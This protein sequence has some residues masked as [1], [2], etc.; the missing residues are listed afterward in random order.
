MWN[1]LSSPARVPKAAWPPPHYVAAWQ[2]ESG[3]TWGQQAELAAIPGSRN[4]V[5][6][7]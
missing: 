2:Q 6:P 4:I 7:S 3:L 1:I 5:Q